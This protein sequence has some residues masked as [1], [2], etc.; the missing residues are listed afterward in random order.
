MWEALAEL[1]REQETRARDRN[2]LRCRTSPTIG[3]TAPALLRAR[4][5]AHVHAVYRTPLGAHGLRIPALCNTLRCP[6]RFWTI[7]LLCITPFARVCAILLVRSSEHDGHEYLQY[8]DGHMEASAD[9]VRAEMQQ[10]ATPTRPTETSGGG[11]SDGEMQ[12]GIDGTDGDANAN[13]TD[14]GQNF[15]GDA[16]GSADGAGEPKLA[17]QSDDEDD[18]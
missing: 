11:D 17:G 6:L 4:A 5:H 12:S 13:A 2:A 7:Q 15:Q 8:R 9:E 1:A 10:A 16:P 14:D 18:L 3:L